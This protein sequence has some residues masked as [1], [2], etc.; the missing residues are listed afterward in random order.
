MTPCISCSLE[1]YVPAFVFEIADTSSNLYQL[2]LDGRY[3]SMVLLQLVSYSALFGHAYTRLLSMA[4]LL[5]LFVCTSS[6]NSPDW[7]LE[8][9]V[10][11]LRRRW[12]YSL[13]CG[14]FLEQKFFIA[15]SFLLE[16]TFASDLRKCTV[17]YHRVGRFGTQGVAVTA[18]QMGGSI[19]SF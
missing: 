1:F 10:L 18:G 4:K 19:T 15:Y 9:S 14:S 5:N 17:I 8:S 11:F 7:L 2:S 12:S 16:L 6:Y 13:S 3:F